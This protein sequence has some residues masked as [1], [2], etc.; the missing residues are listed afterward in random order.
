MLMNARMPRNVQQ[1]SVT[2]TSRS[3]DLT[4]R[5]PPASVPRGTGRRLPRARKLSNSTGKREARNN[6][7][8]SCLCCARV[9][10]DLSGYFRDE[11]R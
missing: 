6:C 7:A 3:S 9:R 10:R 8:K 11:H 1:I 4:G 2:M 5:S